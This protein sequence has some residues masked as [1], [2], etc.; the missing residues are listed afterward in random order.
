[1]SAAAQSNSELIAAYLDAVIYKDA[2]AVD[3]YPDLT[4]R[5]S[6][7]HVFADSLRKRP[8]VPNG[9]E[10][11][12][13]G[14]GRHECPRYSR[15]AKNLTAATRNAYRAEPRGHLVSERFGDT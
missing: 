15:A 1:M 4:C 14:R 13:S 8:D 5:H 3:R 9:P 10:N 11:R 12:K 6:C 7:R 2:S